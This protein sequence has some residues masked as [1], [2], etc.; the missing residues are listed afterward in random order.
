MTY[1]RGDILKHN[2]LDCIIYI[3]SY[4]DRVY[5][6][7]FLDDKNIPISFTYQEHELIS[8]WDLYTNFFSY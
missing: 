2:T 4:R 7:I 6:I 5:S 8:Q 1:K 3:T